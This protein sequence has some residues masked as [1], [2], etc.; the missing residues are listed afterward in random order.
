MY[1]S[2]PRAIVCIEGYWSRRRLGT[3]LYQVERQSVQNSGVE[4]T[5]EYF[6]VHGALYMCACVMYCVCVLCVC[7]SARFGIGRFTTTEE[8]DYTIK[9]CVSSVRRLREMR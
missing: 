2:I 3:F 8:V 4:H 7:V 9:H 6:S 5:T 1:F